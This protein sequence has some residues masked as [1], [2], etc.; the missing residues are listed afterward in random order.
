MPTAINAGKGAPRIDGPRKVTGGAKY[1]SDFNLPGMLYAVP[2]C[3]TIAN[4]KI[5][6]LDTA[7]A[8][9]MPGVRAIYHRANIGKLFRVLV[10]KDFSEDAAIIDEKR[11]PLED[12]IIRYYGQY[13]ALA[14]ADTFEQAQAAARAVKATYQAETPDVAPEL[15]VKDPQPESE[16]GDPD[17]AFTEAPVQI[18]HTYISPAEVHNPIE[19]HATVAQWDGKSFTLYET[20]QGV[21]NHR[22]VMAQVL[23]VPKENLRVISKFLGTG[24]GGK[25]WPWSH[26]A[27]AAAAARHL[28]KPVKLV[29]DRRM[30]F[31]TVG[32]RPRT[33][34]RIR[35]GA[36][37][38]GKLLAFMHDYV[39]HTS[40]LDDY[41]E[42]CGEA[43]PSQ[44]SVPN[45]RVTSALAH[46]NV[47]TP[48]S[49]R[50]PGAVPGLWAT[51]AA[52]D[53]LAVK[54]K[55]D[56]VKLR[57]LN[58]PTIDEGKKVPFSSR[59]L[60]ECFQLGSEKFGWE[61]RNP[62][63]ASMKKDGAIL[64]WGMAGCSWPA[65]RF[66]SEARV[67]LLDTGKARVAVATQDIGTG[68]YTVLA[69]IASE[70]LGIPPEQVDVVLGDT[71]LPLGPISGG[72]MATASVIPAVSEACSKVVELLL[73]AA[74]TLPD[75][76]YAKHKND[77]L[78][79][80]TGQIHAKNEKPEAGLS[81][82]QLLKLGKMGRIVGNGAAK[83]TFGGK[84]TPKVSRHSF[85]CHFVEVTWQPDI[86]RLRVSRVV[87]VIDGGRI[88]NPLAG[89]NQ[90]EGAVVM[91]IGMALL[92]EAIYDPRNGQPI[93]NN[94]ADY[95]LATNAD[96]PSL[97]VHFLDY[98]D[99]EVNEMGARGIGEI[100]LAG[101]AAAVANAV[102]HATG[103]RIRELPIKIENLLA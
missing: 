31:A 25:L 30:M 34:Q 52:I 99:M 50:G 54:L 84:E 82:V 4:G 21:V 75:S 1:T 39:N 18:D 86:A 59:H 3:A 103:K 40:I 69:L 61:K 77:D 14:V 24:F 9:K 63:V 19:L 37:P 98:P 81:F 47:G 32:H 48:T 44:Y 49:M 74:T 64:G 20:T 71:D 15:P 22:A 42:N 87:T 28:G 5:T 91:G 65:E 101:F 97:D 53:E 88:L 94:L 72:S 46:Q 6:S 7:A 23:G 76:K 60:V 95:I 92:E 62:E 79:Y 89:R 56:P 73:K 17:K 29:L 67:E 27:L 12:D 38:D 55:I 83:G 100:G 78:A 10:N 16:R 68:T 102:Y 93:N 85:G 8:E 13:V 33:Q 90:I 66:S 51:E 45:L 11:P 36:T 96:C 35:I 70:K 2:V 43:T 26:D 41:Q 57:I 80:T 58:E